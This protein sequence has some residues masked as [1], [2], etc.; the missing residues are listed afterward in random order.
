MIIT[1]IDLFYSVLMVHSHLSLL[2]C[3][4]TLWCNSKLQLAWSSCNAILFSQCWDQCLDCGRLYAPF[5]SVKNSSM[6][7]QHEHFIFCRHSNIIR[8]RRW[9]C[10]EVFGFTVT[11]KETLY[12]LHLPIR[13]TLLHFPHYH[14]SPG[15][16]RLCRRFLRSWTS[17]MWMHKK[18]GAT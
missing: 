13:K 8:G 6:L 10:R 2:K 11:L 16:S 15:I 3:N 7:C 17:C 4:T 9:P 18:C 5:V 12:F 14:W 1:N